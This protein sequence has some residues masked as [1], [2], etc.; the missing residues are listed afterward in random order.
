MKINTKILLSILILS[1]F[2]HKSCFSGT[3][4]FPQIYGFHCT[5]FEIEN[6]PKSD[7]NDHSNL[8]ASAVVD[9]NVTCNGGNNGSA[10]IMASNG[11]PPYTFAW[12]NGETTSIATGL[13]AGTYSWT[14]KD[15]VL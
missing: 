8:I 1:V 11:S 13:S 4:I 6:A 15:A 2:W 9:T 10:T 5:Y 3:I 7:Q 12:S 14:V